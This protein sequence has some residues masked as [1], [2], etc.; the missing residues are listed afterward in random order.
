M[1][2]RDDGVSL[3][4][5]VVAMLLL[6]V[7]SLGVLPLMIGLSQRSVDNRTALSAT[8]FG[9]DELAK[10]QAAFPATPGTTT[11][12][13]ADLLARAAAPAVTDA[14][15]GFTARVTVGVSACPAAY[16]AAVPVA[17]TVSD[18]GR[19]VTTLTSQVRVGAP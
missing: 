9:R 10:I 2:A 19:V 11:T 8:S 14:A 18:A 17:V 15:S 16:P 13:C 1:L 5:V 12:R 7:L 6:A 4:E 3:V